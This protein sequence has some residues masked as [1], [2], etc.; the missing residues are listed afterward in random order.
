M[1]KH[2][3]VHFSLIIC[4]VV[5]YGRLKTKKNFIILALNVVAVAYERWSLTRDKVQVPNIVI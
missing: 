5:A 1:L 4:Q 3:I 2:R